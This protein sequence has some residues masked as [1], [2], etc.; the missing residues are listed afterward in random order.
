M[1]YPS[2]HFLTAFGGL[3]PGGEAWS[4]SFRST[5]EFGGDPSGP[6]DLGAVEPVSVEIRAWWLDTNS[7]GV[8]SSSLGWVK[9]NRI[10]VDGRYLRDTTN[11]VE[12]DPV[13]AGPGGA[14]SIK[15]NQVALAVTLETG[16]Q[17]GLAHRGR[18]FLP[19]PRW[20]VLGD[21]RISAA[22]AASAATGVAS[23]FSALNAIPEFGTVAIYSDVREGA[24][25]PVTDVT[26]GRVYDT[27]RSR[28]TSMAEE[29]VPP[30][31]VTGGS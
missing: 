16:Q 11:L 29:R 5:P 1:P 9:H 14:S 24:M 28:R 8:I 12:F 27:I 4:C 7:P 3:L 22:D 23:L 20:N 26:C 31:P 15:P 2:E 25:R 19:A 30:V 10:G 18:M 6:G 13:I 21:G 17:R